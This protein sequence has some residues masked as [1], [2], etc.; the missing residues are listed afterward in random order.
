MISTETWLKIR[1]TNITCIDRLADFLQL[2]APLR[3]QLLRKSAFPLNLPLHIAHKI[4]KNTLD[5]PLLRQ[6]VPLAEE[7]I[8]VD[9]FGCDPV[10]E[11]NYRL[12][13]NLLKKY[14]ARALLIPT[15]ACGM[16]CRYCF[17]R[18]FDYTAG[19]ISLEKE[20][21]VIAEDSSISEVIL[22]GGD[23]LSLPN[24]QLRELLQ[25]LETI[26]HLKR[27]RFHSRMPIG[28]PERIDTELVQM[29]SGCSLQTV[30]VLHSNHVKELDAKVLT[31]LKQLQ[32]SGIP[33]LCQSVLLRGVNDTEEALF[34][35]F[36]TL[37]NQGIL[38]YYLHQL[39]P[40]SG[41]AHFHV[42][43]ERGI[44]L[45]RE[46]QKRL[47]GYSL[48]RYVKELPGEPHKTIIY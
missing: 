5:D 29:L 39:D 25:Q 13:P 36:E 30:F 28:I 45:M 23:P 3:K 21:Q 7:E 34:E 42:D 46:L 11:S 19:R 44:A 16:H 15:Q 24:N 40:V 17:R 12:S 20:V 26:P 4:E 48:P 1:R 37:G 14:A 33:V 41:A 35:L 10:L 31:S 27:L 22:S 6:F 18:H 9:G 2:D 47:S 43:E 38:P 8:A 32:Q